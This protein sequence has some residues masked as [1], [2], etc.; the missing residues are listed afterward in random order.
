MREDKTVVNL[1][2]DPS[3]C[4]NSSPEL[5]GSPLRMGGRTHSTE[6]LYSWMAKQDTTGGLKGAEVIK[7]LNRAL[8]FNCYYRLFG[9][10]D[11]HLANSIIR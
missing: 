9:I 7:M 2:S 1:G 10:K 11:R 4:T 3:V 5:T 6:D 8:Q